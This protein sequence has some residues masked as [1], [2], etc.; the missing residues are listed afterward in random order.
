MLDG[1]KTKQ[2]EC[3]THEHDSIEIRI[4]SACIKRLDIS[5]SMDVSNGT[6]SVKRNPYLN[7][8]NENY[9]KSP[10]FFGFLTGGFILIFIIQKTEDSA[11]DK[12]INPH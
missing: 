9:M 7:M 1:K 3:L 12:Y 8:A 10:I 4:K 11:S 2:N 6:D 5:W